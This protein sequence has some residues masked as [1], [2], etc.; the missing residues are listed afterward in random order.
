MQS[1]HASNAV[2]PAAS[3]P[4]RLAVQTLSAEVAHL[5]YA[6]AFCTAVLFAFIAVT[7]D[8]R[9]WFVAP[10]LICGVLIGTDAMG[11]FTGTR[12][13]F[14]P[15][16]MIGLLGLHFFFLAPLLHVYW[17]YWIDDVKG[18]ADWRVWLGLMAVLNATGL[19]LYRWA[20]TETRRRTRPTPV[21]QGRWGICRARFGVFLCVLLVVTS[22]L[23]LWIYSM[24]GGIAGYIDMA[25]EGREAFRNMGPLFL[26]SE[27]FPALAL[28]GFVV[29]GADSRGRDL[30]LSSWVS[31][32]FFSCSDS[33]SADSEGAEARSSGRCSG[34]RA[35]CICGSE[36]SRG[37]CCWPASAPSS[38][39]CPFY[40]LYK[41]SGRGVIDILQGPSVITEL[42][43]KA[44]RPIESTLLGDLARS[45]VQAHLLYR[46]VA[47]SDAEFAWGRT[48]LGAAALLVPRFVWPDRIAGKIEMVPTYST[49][50]FVHVGRVRVVA[51][52]RPGRRSADQLRSSGGASQLRRAGMAGAARAALRVRTACERHSGAGAAAASKPVC[53]DGCLRRRQPLVLRRPERPHAVSPPVVGPA[54]GRGC[55]RVTVIVT[56]E[57]R[58]ARTPDGRVWTPAQFWYRFWRR[59]LEVFDAVRIL[60]RVRDVDTVGLE[61]QRVDGDGATVVAVPHY[62]GPWECLRKAVG[63]L[64]AVRGAVDGHDAVIL[65]VNSALAT[66]VHWHL[67]RQ[68]RPYGVEVVSDPHDVFAPGVV[69]DPLR[70]LVR[71][72]SSYAQAKQ[73]ADAC[74]ASYVTERVL[75]SRYPCLRLEVSV[76]D[77]EIG[78]E[79]GFPLA[80]LDSDGGDRHGTGETVSSANARKRNRRFN[81]IT[82]AS[83]DRLYKGTD[84]LIGAVARVVRDGHDIELVIVG[85]GAYREA[86]VRQAAAQ[87]IAERVIFTGLLREEGVRRRLDESDLFV[88]P[89]RAEGLPRA[90]IEAMARGVACIGSRVGGIPE[91]LQADRLV[92]PGDEEGLS[93]AI[94][95]ML[96]H[97]HRRQE[98]A[99]RD[100]AKAMEF[101]ADVLGERRRRFYRHIRHATDEW[102]RGSADLRVCTTPADV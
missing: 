74:G 86:L 12:D 42:E 25:S 38:C 46:S 30:S 72:Y 76:S 16:G 23:Q 77:V 81:V 102:L 53:H 56:I 8:M 62:I 37:A 98:I 47:P 64:S 99:R 100:Y 50:R 21:P 1:S 33:S 10:V 101:R 57:E 90:M 9:H 2:L 93:T 7:P 68:K 97:P 19:L 83:L 51:R 58:L 66:C 59:Y 4:R 13:I 43:E 22:M 44:R 88:L 14:D 39:S 17:G 54:H 92:A 89:S 63:I 75:Q 60:A 32:C 78:G 84:V 80:E 40:G 70:P 29:Y 73:C 69:S 11:L 61:S 36:R 31:C 87:G 6:T 95:E 28:I 52:L 94:T 34:R 79:N 15:I 55:S 24:Y 5:L 41:G 35:S 96:T 82:V 26:V 91:L 49:A 18:P 20:R 3:N 65:R 85:D 71:K 48:Y 27:S 45:D 67:H